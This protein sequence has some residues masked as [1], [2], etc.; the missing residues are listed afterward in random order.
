MPIGFMYGME[1]EL[2]SYQTNWEKEA[3]LGTLVIAYSLDKT[4][5]CNELE[6]DELPTEIKIL[7]TVASVKPFPS[8]CNRTSLA[9]VKS[10]NVAVS[11]PV[12]LTTNNFLRAGNVAVGKVEIAWI[13]FKIVNTQ[14]VE[15]RETV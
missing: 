11:N 6:D 15:N 10:G 5:S 14:R 12:Q 7:L 4:S 9:G 13:L 8:K 1:F 3:I 2:T